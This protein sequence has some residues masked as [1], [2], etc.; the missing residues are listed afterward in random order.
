MM[1]S[2]SDKREER[3]KQED[4]TEEIPFRLDRESLLEEA[5]VQLR[6]EPGEKTTSD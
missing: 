6:L 4:D 2:K 5:V 1:F 3:N